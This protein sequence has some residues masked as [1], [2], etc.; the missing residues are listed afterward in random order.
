VVNGQLTLGAMI[1]IQ[2]IIGQLNGPV[3]Q[4]IGFVRSAQDAQLSLQRLN[5]IHQQQD[6]EPEKRQFLY[7]LPENKDIT[8][9][10][11]NFTYPGAGNEPVL[12]NI[13]LTIPEGKTTAVVGMSGSGKTTLIKLLLKFY[14]LDSGKIHLGETNLDD[15]SHR[16]WRRH[17]GVVMQEGFIFSDN[18]AQNIAVGED[19]PDMQKLQHAVKVANIQD[20]IESLPLGLN[21]KIG[22]E[23]NSISQGQ[24]QRMLI[25]RAVYKDPKFIFFDEATNAL[26]ANNERTIME[27]LEDFFQNRSVIVV[28]HRLSTVKNAD[29]LVVLSEGK[30]VE[31]GTHAELIRM[32]GAYYELVKNQL[33]LGD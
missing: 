30:I 26:D 13:N 3:E 24:K 25:A 29:N 21:T 12:N 9:K 5:E 28:A 19:H 27:N 20:F 23:G 1:A 14:A 17:C 33:E 11:L 2:Y 22:S 6:E 8:I 10:N 18:I 15:I 31:Q 4:L 32:K 16:A 7:A